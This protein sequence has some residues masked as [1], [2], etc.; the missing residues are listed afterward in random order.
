MS[1]VQIYRVSGGVCRFFPGAAL[2][3]AETQIASRLARLEIIEPSAAEPRLRVMVKEPIEFKIGEEI[4]LSEDYDEMPRSLASLLERVA[5]E[6]AEPSS[7]RRA[8]R[9]PSQPYE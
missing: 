4:G 7:Q 9:S 6:A 2:H 5:S 1:A 3:L 8:R